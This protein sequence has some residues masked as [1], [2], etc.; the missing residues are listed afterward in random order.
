MHLGDKEAVIT[1]AEFC[2]RVPVQKDVEERWKTRMENEDKITTNA[3]EALHSEVTKMR[4]KMA[5]EVVCM[6]NR[7]QGSAA[8]TVSGSTRSGGNV[9][10]FAS[11]LMQNTFVASRVELKRRCCWRNIRGT[12]IEAKQLVSM[13]KAR[14]KQD[15]LNMFDWDMT[16]RDQGSFCGSKR[17]HSHGP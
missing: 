3:I 16:D 7:H 12:G 15:D 2:I 17:G 14:L 10:N 4:A 11:K 5:E 1:Q 6:K 13:A 9:G 8:S